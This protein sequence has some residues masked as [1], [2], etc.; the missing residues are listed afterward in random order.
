MREGTDGPHE[1]VAKLATLA[2]P[3]L[4]RMT[5]CSWSALEST[6]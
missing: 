2:G 5:L 6:V 4:E 3:A 1:N